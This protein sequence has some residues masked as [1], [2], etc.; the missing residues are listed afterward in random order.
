M[1]REKVRIFGMVYMFSWGVMAL[2]DFIAARMG[3]FSFRRDFLSEGELSHSQY[4]SI[5]GLHEMD[6]MRC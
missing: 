5:A 6:Y 2:I 3:F 4:N 1:R